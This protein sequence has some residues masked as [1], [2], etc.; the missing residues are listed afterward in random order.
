MS[1]AQPLSEAELVRG[2]ISVQRI[3]DDRVGAPPDSEG[4]ST[5]GAAASQVASATVRHL[6][7]HVEA[8]ARRSFAHWKVLVF[9]Q[10][11]SVLRFVVGASSTMLYRRCSL[12]V[13]ATQTGLTYYLLLLFHGLCFFF[14]RA[15][16]CGKSEKSGV[17]NLAGH[18]D[19][20]GRSN[21]AIDDVANKSLRGWF[22][23]PLH[24][25]LL[26]Y[27]LIALLHVEGN[28]LFFL[29]LRFTT[30]TSV[31]IFANLAVPSA[32][33][34]SRLF[35]RRQYRAV[36]VL[37]VAVCLFGVAL[38]VWVDITEQR[39]HRAETGADD[40]DSEDEFGESAVE[41]YPQRMLG[42]FL[43]V[44][45]GIM[46][47]VNDV[48]FERAVRTHGSGPREFLPM[49]G[50][51]GAIISTIQVL[52]FELPNLAQ[53][54]VGSYTEGGPSLGAETVI[55]A[56]AEGEVP[57]VT[58]SMTKE[59][60][61]CTEGQAISL[62]LV[63]C[64][65]STYVLVAGVSHFLT[66]S[67]SALLNLS[68]L[69]E[70]WWSVIFSIVAVGYVPAPLFYLALVLV[71]SGVFLYEMGPS[72]VDSDGVHEKVLK[73]D[74]SLAE[75]AAGKFTSESMKDGVELSSGEGFSSFG[76]EGAAPGESDLP[77][78]T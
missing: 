53:F 77:D 11:L 33:V 5:D 75:V 13:P 29:S 17:G 46:F 27:F 35:L 55:S 26:T 59:P 66:V 16:G 2:A 44:V 61:P 3:G 48:L 9:G 71:L 67:E 10:V 69:T 45:G 42:D 6:G 56:A 31:T 12:S 14:P 21:S 78:I 64:S 22:P 34:F 40:T 49:L 76:E 43:A 68:Y 70:D 73:L 54:S 74:D 57:I 50:L 1:R 4:T 41:E 51:F 65:I 25:P 23:V 47:G 58:P 24:A 63:G 38:N 28:Y 52:L 30:F 37:G 62:L 72:P 20:S 39:F 32:M 7:K 36:H 8:G 19:V 18:A 15:F 60:P